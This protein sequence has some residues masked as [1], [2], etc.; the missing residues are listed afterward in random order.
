MVYQVQQAQM[1]DPYKTDDVYYLALWQDTTLLWCSVT[2][3][4]SIKKLNQSGWTSRQ[5]Q[6]VI[7]VIEE[8]CNGDISWATT[9]RL[10]NHEPIEY[11]TGYD[12]FMN[13]KLHVSKDVLLPRPE[14]EDLLDLIFQHIPTTNALQTSFLDIGTG[15]PMYRLV[16]KQRYSTAQVHAIDVCPKALAIAEKNSQMHGLSLSLRE[17]DIL[18]LNEWKGGKLKYIVSNPIFHPLNAT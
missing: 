5:I 8:D 11:I 14:T 9:Q 13:L 12:Y 6:H 7:K 18:K 10:L 15:S 1:L 3:K 17:C 4:E 16:L 2:R